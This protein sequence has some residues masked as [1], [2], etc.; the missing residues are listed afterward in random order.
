MIAQQIVNGLMLGSIYVLVA[1]AF[2]MAIGVLNF[3]NFSIPGTFM[4]GGTVAWWLMSRGTGWMLAITV[5]L[6]VGGLVGYFVYSLTYRPSDGRDPE[7]PLVSSLGVLV[8]L[9]NLAI[10]GMGSDQQA[11]PQI[12]AAF[13]IRLGAIVLG[14]AQILSLHSRLEQ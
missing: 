3:L 14:P 8:L 1:V 10:I 11:F 13:A 7:I 2:T 12:P 4:V 5:A 6:I 9:Q